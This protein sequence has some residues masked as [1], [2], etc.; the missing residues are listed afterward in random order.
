[1]TRP[2]WI[3]PLAFAL[4]FCGDP[5]GPPLRVVLE[6]GFDGACEGGDCGWALVAGPEGSARWTA[7]W[8][9]WDRAVALDPGAVIRGE[10]TTTRWDPARWYGPGVDPIRL[11]LSAR[12]EP[13]GRLHVVLELAD[14]EGTGSIVA[15]GALSAGERWE[16][17]EET[18]SVS[19][20]ESPVPGLALRLA[21]TG[22][23]CDVTHVRVV[24]GDGGE[25][26][27]C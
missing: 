27:T 21:A 6:D 13:R 15:V 18:L 1:M 3:S 17:V 25:D 26:I 9:E 10:R 12:C 7:G 20:E 2:T 23:R 8:A 24:V 4:V 14:R 22:A 16:F 19:T 5:V 11:Q